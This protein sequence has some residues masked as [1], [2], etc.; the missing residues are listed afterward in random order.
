MKVLA[1]ILLAILVSYSY[2]HSNLSNAV[3]FQAGYFDIAVLV[4]V[5][6]ALRVVLRL[7]WQKVVSFSAVYWTATTML[8]L[9][10]A[11]PLEQSSTALGAFIAI[12]ML[13]AISFVIWAI[14]VT[15]TALLLHFVARNQRSPRRSER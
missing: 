14:V 10:N 3:G 7:S 6:V 4:L 15:A 13:G 2:F 5:L 1:V 9:W 11:I 8:G 12:T